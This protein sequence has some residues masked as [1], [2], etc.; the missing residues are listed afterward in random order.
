MEKMKGRREDTEWGPWAMVIK[1]GGANK[2]VER[3]YEER[4]G[5]QSERRKVREEGREG[6][7]PRHLAAL[8]GQSLRA[9]L[10]KERRD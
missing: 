1:V 4:T 6:G 9:A 7:A 8:G 5:Y 2:E 10:P 3:R